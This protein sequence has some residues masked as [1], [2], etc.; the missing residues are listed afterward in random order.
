MYVKEMLSS[1]LRLRGLYVA[2]SHSGTLDR[3][4]FGNGLAH[5]TSVVGILYERLISLQY[6]SQYSLP[7]I[8]SE[9]LLSG[10]S[11]AIFSF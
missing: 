7:E 9:H 8:L 2:L 5:D 3:F 1:H 4:F 11:E 6:R 10:R